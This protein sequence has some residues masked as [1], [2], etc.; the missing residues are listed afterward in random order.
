[1]RVLFLTPYLPYP[2]RGGGEQRMYHMLRHVAARHE[3]HLLSFGA[4]DATIEPLREF[5]D[6][7]MVAPPTH[8]IARRLRTLLFSATPDMALRG[9]DTQFNELV[10][11]TLHQ[12]AF[13]VV[14]CESIEMAQYGMLE[15]GSGTA[16]KRPLWCYDA[17]NAEYQIQRRAFFT[18]LRRIR[19]WPVAGY[20]LIQWRKL[21]RYERRLA[22]LFDLVLA[23]SEADR[24]VLRKL[25]RLPVELVPNGVDTKHFRHRN[26]EQSQQPSKPSLLFTGTLD[27]RPNIDALQ[28]FVEMVWGRLHSRRPDLSFRIVGQ[29]P[30]DQVRRLGQIPGIEV[31]GPVDD[32]R[33]WFEQATAYVLPM[34]VGGG[35]RLKLMETWAMGTPCVTT[36]M[37]AEGVAGFEPGIHALVAD[38]PEVFLQHVERM[39]DNPKLRRSLARAGRELVEERYDWQPII[40]G[41]EQAWSRM[42]RAQAPN[43]VSKK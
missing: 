8:H 18:D 19:T 30:S 20:S 7:Q 35:V 42:I 21:L 31:I 17:F 27:F 28:W 38:T 29:R 40:V 9:R 41:M 4:P 25:S 24:T 5:A 36:H 33:P 22:Q 12:H 15:R 23:V 34:R 32:V 3:V 13:D 1:M 6:V 43:H 14:Q 26:G 37:G 16:T 2:P 39:L 11:H 10:H